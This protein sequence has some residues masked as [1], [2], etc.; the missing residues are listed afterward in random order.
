MNNPMNNPALAGASAGVKDPIGCRMAIG[1]YGEII[2][3]PLFTIGPLTLRGGEANWRLALAAAQPLW[4]GVA[5]DAIERL[6]HER[7]LD[8]EAELQEK[9]E[10][11]KATVAVLTWKDAKTLDAGYY[12]ARITGIEE[13]TGEY[14]PQFQFQFVVLDEEGEETDSEMR[15]WCS[16]SWGEKA[17][18]FAWAKAILGKRCPGSGQ[19]L[20][21]DRLKGKS[22]DIQVEVGTNKAGQPNSKITALLPYKT[23]SV[24]RA[25]PDDEDDKDLPF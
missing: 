2:G 21:T 16:Q 7:R 13:T 1:S 23:V 25:E 10:K 18:L 11:D 14:G 19:P 8:R 4:L 17:K 3:W 15:A 6:E 24:K 20:D 12:P 9:A 5:W 22:V